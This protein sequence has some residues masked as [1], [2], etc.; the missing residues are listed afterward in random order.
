MISLTVQGP[1]DIRS[2]LGFTCG[3]TSE[4]RKQ[5]GKL[6]GAAV[7][8]LLTHN[9]APLMIPLF[10][11]AASAKR[12]GHIGGELAEQ[13][14]RQAKGLT[15]DERERAL[16]FAADAVA[17]SGFSLEQAAYVSFDVPSATRAVARFLDTTLSAA[18]HSQAT[19]ALRLT[20]ESLFREAR[21]DDSSDARAQ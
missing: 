14:A 16:L 9:P 11:T 4:G 18:E 21:K 1:Q 2:S 19:M 13:F 17:A 15:P 7:A 8:S 6:F 20:Y 10:E 3:V 12:K 5:A